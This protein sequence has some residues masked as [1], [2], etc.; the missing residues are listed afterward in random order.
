MFPEPISF[1]FVFPLRSEVFSFYSSIAPLYGYIKQFSISYN[2]GFL[3]VRPTVF[4]WIFIKISGF[5]TSDPGF[6]FILPQE[7]SR[8][9]S[10]N[11]KT[12]RQK[13]TKA[14]SKGSP[15]LRVLCVFGLSPRCPHT[16]SQCLGTYAS[17]FLFARMNSV[18]V[19][20]R[21]VPNTEKSSV[22]SPPVCGSSMP[23]VFFTVMV[24]TPDLLSNLIDA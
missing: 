8:K 4:S 13:K 3:K 20:T 24:Y 16:G 23:G 15:C 11:R 18:E 9:A 7:E 14:V 12:L 5:F 22:P 17:R 19:R 21:I 6:C 1:F 10:I 2:L